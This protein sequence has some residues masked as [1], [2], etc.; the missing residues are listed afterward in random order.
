MTHDSLSLDS[1][2]WRIRIQIFET[3]KSLGTGYH[4][5]DLGTCD[6]FTAEMAADQHKTGENLPSHQRLEAVTVEIKCPIHSWRPAPWGFCDLCEDNA[7]DALLDQL[8][9]DPDSVPPYA[10]RDEI[11]V[12]RDLLAAGRLAEDDLAGI[13]ELPF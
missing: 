4:Y 5:H 1:A 11:D 7:L 13:D 2:R 9:A 3:W 6:Y 12:A 10:K 8:E